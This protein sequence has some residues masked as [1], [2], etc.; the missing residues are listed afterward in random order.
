VASL[1]LGPL[2]RHVG[3]HHATLWVETDG[4]CTVEVLGRREPTFTMAGHH[5]ALVR[6]EDLPAGTA[7]PYEVRLDG[8]LAWPPSGSPYPAGR[9]RTLEESRPVRLSFGS[10]RYAAMSAQPDGTGM[11][12]DALDGYA[13]RLAT[14]P[15]EQWPE[16]LLL[17]GDQVYADELTPATRSRI[18][19][20]PGRPPSPPDD[21]VAD[22]EEYTWLYRESW[23][24]P[25]VR[26]LLS[27]VPT[28]M[29]FDDHDVHD[30]WN[31]SRSWRQDMAATPWWPERIIGALTSYWIYQHL[32]NLSPEE[33]DADPL[34]RDVRARAG[35]GED[36]AGLLRDFALA[37]D[38]EAD[39]AKGARWSFWRDLGR[40]RLVVVDSRCGRILDGQRSMIGEREFAWVADRVR[41]EYDH[42]V[43]GTSLPWLLAP[44]VHDVEAWD[45]R[46][47]E[48]RRP[49]LARLGERLR[50]AGDLEHWAAFQ[51]SFEGLA[52]LLRAVARGEHG[53][54]APA[55]ICVL[56]G[57]VHHSYVCEADLGPEG[58]GRCATFQITCS[59]V[60]NRVPATMRLAFRLGW[61]RVAEHGTRLVLGRVARIP[62]PSLTWR[63]IAGPVFGN[64]V[65]SLVLDGRRADLVIESPVSPVSPVSPPSLA[66]LVSRA[67]R[68]GAAPGAPA[69]PADA[70]SGLRTVVRRTLAG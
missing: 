3:R 55:T 59:P 12:P 53:G 45:E 40:T 8:D 61:S 21:Q 49:R 56:S 18:A 47:S 31:T 65:A 41:G 48:H 11:P 1:L 27:T 22:F 23:Q 52:G 33:L 28:A 39:G 66:S 4:P 63:R 69:G 36:V 15:P 9:I 46:L 37:A 51:A 2:L 30:D 25:P 13:R 43:I 64:A 5:Y 68:A 57:D 67:R 54:P 6:V 16:L 50:R 20:R 17:L 29:I 19:V 42:L 38:R 14:T 70:R 62:R 24:D 60:R 7:T 34:Y 10:C 58:P 35:T 44:A 26:W 32:G